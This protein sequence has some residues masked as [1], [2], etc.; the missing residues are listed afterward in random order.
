M[1]RCLP[2]NT[3]WAELWVWPY[4]LSSVTFFLENQA[5][6]RKSNF[7]Y[8]DLVLHSRFK[9]KRP[10]RYDVDRSTDRTTDWQTERQIDRQ[11][12][13]STDKM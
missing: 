9:T 12:D 7:A 6:R 1:R 8:F 3:G 2:N 11:N 13:R 4:S 5:K 10:L